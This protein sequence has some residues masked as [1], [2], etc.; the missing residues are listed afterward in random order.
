VG[1]DEMGDNAKVGAD[2]TR[3]R[4]QYQSAESLPEHRLNTWVEID[5]MAASAAKSD[6]DNKKVRLKPDVAAAVS[7]KRKTY[8]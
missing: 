8:S 7:A 6:Y 1:H 2:S 4:D 5:S 3:F